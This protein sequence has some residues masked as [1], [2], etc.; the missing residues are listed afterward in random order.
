MYNNL[1]SLCE[2]F[3]NNPSGKLNPE[4]FSKLDLQCFFESPMIYHTTNL[5]IITK[6]T[7]NKPKDP[8]S[9]TYNL[10][11]SCAYMVVPKGWENHYPALNQDCL[12]ILSHGKHH[13][14][15]STFINKNINESFMN[16]SKK[17]LELYVTPEIYFSLTGGNYDKKNLKTAI[18]A[19]IV[20]PH[21]LKR[22]IN[23]KEI[24]LN[25]KSR[26]AS[27]IKLKILNYI[28]TENKLL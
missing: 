20:V 19:P 28:P 27:K 7:I 17:T 3:V 4:E 26:L 1:I 10:Q 8:K 11:N 12:T 5:R 23:N 9:Y 2:S 21:L 22:Q 16:T 24:M 6:E 25:E 15:M 18:I 14:V 13:F